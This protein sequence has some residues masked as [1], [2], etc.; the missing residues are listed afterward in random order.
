MQYMHLFQCTKAKRKIMLVNQ[1]LPDI[2]A[3]W[4]LDKKK[5]RPAACIKNGMIR[6]GATSQRLLSGNGV[7]KASGTR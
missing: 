2:I 3:A 4:P 7:E 6:R 5:V 1:C